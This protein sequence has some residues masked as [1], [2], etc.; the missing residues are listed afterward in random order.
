MM[1]PVLLACRVLDLKEAVMDCMA[2]VDMI[3][4][5][6]EQATRAEHLKELKENLAPLVDIYRI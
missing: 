4:V 5:E 1:D 6:A 2:L 3:S